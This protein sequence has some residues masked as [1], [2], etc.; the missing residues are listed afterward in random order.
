[1]VSDRTSDQS[2]EI[3]TEVFEF[4][5]WEWVSV[6]VRWWEYKSEDEADGEVEDEGADL[7]EGVDYTE[8]RDKSVQ[9]SELWESECY[10]VEDHEGNTFCLPYT[11]GNHI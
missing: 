11:H 2:R 1:M 6:R 5:G 10:D 8:G 7:D 4:W 3:V 9:N